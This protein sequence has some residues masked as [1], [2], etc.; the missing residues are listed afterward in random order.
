MEKV[1]AQGLGV[2]A[3]SYDNRDILKH[4]SDRKGIT[5]PLLSDI[6]SKIIRS[7]GVLNTNIAEGH[8]FYGIPFP[9]TYIVDSKGKVLSKYFEQWHRQRYTADTILI[10][11]YGLEGAKKT[12]IKTD[13][14]KVNAFASQ[15]TIRPGNRISIV[16]DIELSEQMHIYAP[17]V[18]GYKSVSLNIQE[19][20]A[21]KVHDT[22]Y[23]DP[24]IMYLEVIKEK[25]PI[26]KN[27]VR[28]RR[29]LTLSPGYR[30]KNLVISAVLNYQACD[31]KT[32]Y[33]PVDI[34]LK[35]ELDVEAHDFQLAPASKLKKPSFSS[36]AKKK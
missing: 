34:P 35:F 13:H 10:K 19:D 14:L 2:V 36:P 17:G 24:K 21:L 6:N 22:E 25:V 30:Q 32:C 11:E 1:K 29:D 3:I 31:E 20:P 9:G 12:E 33:L 18:E 16:L 5:Y 27:S 4:F 23:P 8:P 26:Y 15:Y 7:F 28:I